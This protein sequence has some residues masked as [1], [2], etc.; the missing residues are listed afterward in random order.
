MERDTRNHFRPIHEEV[1][2][3]EDG[4]LRRSVEFL[5]C[6]IDESPGFLFLEE[7]VDSS[8][9]LFIFSSAAGFLLTS[10]R[11]LI[12]LVERECSRKLL[13]IP[14]TMCITQILL[15]SIMTHKDSRSSSA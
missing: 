10:R 8:K 14:G 12:S 15:R 4:S 13:L 2:R 6:Q 9:G 1:H 7:S 5:V 11:R 3:T